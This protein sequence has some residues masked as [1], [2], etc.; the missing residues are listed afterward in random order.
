M[1]DPAFSTA[2]RPHPNGG[3]SGVENAAEVSH[4]QIPRNCE[5]YS[6]ADEIAR[7]EGFA[8][9]TGLQRRAGEIMG[10]GEAQA[11]KMYRALGLVD[12]TAA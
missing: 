7:D 4:D 1:S 2:D 3:A 6:L 11:S 12:A 10:V 8:H 9:G 5:R